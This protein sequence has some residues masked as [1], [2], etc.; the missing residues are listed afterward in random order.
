MNTPLLQELKQHLASITKAEFQKEWSEIKELGLEGPTIEEFLRSISY[1]IKVTENIDFNMSDNT[2]YS[3]ITIT[4][5][6]ESDYS[7]AA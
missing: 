2:M 3:N 4:S 6:G 7:D 1:G 5:S